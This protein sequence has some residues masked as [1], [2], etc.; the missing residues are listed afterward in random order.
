MIFVGVL[1][2]LVAL[3]FGIAA[4]ADFFLLVRVSVGCKLDSVTRKLVIRE[5]SMIGVGSLSF[6]CFV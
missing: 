2:L 5:S 4:L 3:G 6:E 1:M